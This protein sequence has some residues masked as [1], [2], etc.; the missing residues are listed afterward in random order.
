MN[1]RSLLIFLAVLTVGCTIIGH[2]KPPADWPKLR[3]IEHHV[4]SNVMADV[5][6]KYVKMP[7]WMR[8]AGFNIEGCALIHFDTSE[9]HIWVSSDFP[10]A[11]VLE[12]ERLHCEG[13]DHVGSSDLTDGWAKWKGGIR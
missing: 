2:V 11:R 7:L 12:H 1:F 9:C 5:C 4:P 8:L 13:H 6:Y 3:V 10:E